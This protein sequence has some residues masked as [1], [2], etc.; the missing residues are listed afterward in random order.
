MSGTAERPRD[1]Q[2]ALGSDHPQEIVC[3]I[4]SC[5]GVCPQGPDR[6]PREHDAHGGK[7]VCLN[8]ADM[9][10]GESVIESIW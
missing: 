5:L 6:A 7:G 4:I 2:E 10:R 1:G 8:L 9:T 3:D